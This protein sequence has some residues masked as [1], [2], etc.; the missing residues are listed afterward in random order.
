MGLVP[1]GTTHDMTPLDE[2]PIRTLTSPPRPVT[3]DV[4]V[5]MSTAP[6]FPVDAMPV[7]NVIAPLTPHP[8]SRNKPTL[9]HQRKV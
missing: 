9:P 3:W 5:S 4:P 1:E 8:A 2:S 7:E 6:E